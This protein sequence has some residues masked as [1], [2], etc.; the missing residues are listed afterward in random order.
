[1]VVE[2]D[3]IPAWSVAKAGCGAEGVNDYGFCCSSIATGLGGLLGFG[4]FALAATHA[5]EM[6]RSAT[7][8]A[9]L[10]IRGAVISSYPGQDKTT[11]HVYVQI[12]T[13]EELSFGF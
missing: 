13:I 4:G 6:V 11:I 10:A 8:V 9:D 12:Q 1:M 2:R 7:L 5:C 3:G